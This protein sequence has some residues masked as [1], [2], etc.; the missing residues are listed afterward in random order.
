MLDVVRGGKSDLKVLEKGSLA[1]RELT[2][3]RPGV[4]RSVFAMISAMICSI[5]LQWSERERERETIIAFC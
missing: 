2:R 1:E 5:C 3:Q 4:L